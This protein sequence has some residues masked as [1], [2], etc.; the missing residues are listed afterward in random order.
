MCMFQHVR[1]PRYIQMGPQ[2]LSTSWFISFAWFLELRI[3]A[4]YAALL[5]QSGGLRLAG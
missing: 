4:R 3:D 2:K 5:V 1:V